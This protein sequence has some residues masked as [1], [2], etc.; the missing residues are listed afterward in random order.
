MQ[1]DRENQ[2]QITVYKSML[3]PT[4]AGQNS[5]LDA[6]FE[7][8]NMLLRVCIHLWDETLFFYK[9]RSSDIAIPPSPAQK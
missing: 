8:Q 1:C 3:M 9:S 2:N 6:D 5:S 4:P 7:G